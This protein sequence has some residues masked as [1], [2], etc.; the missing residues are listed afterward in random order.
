MKW[1]K[2]ERTRQ[3]E[4]RIIKVDMEHAA[5][6][7]DWTVWNIYIHY[8]CMIT[9][10]ELV[11]CDDCR[12]LFCLLYKLSG[13]LTS[14]SSSLSSSSSS[15]L[16]VNEANKCRK[17]WFFSL[18]VFLAL[19]L[20]YYYQRFHAWMPLYILWWYFN[21]KLLLI[22]FHY[23]RWKRNWNLLLLLFFAYQSSFLLYTVIVILSPVRHRFGCFL[24]VCIASRFGLLENKN[25]ANYW[26]RL[27]FEFVPFQNGKM[28]TRKFSFFEIRNIINQIRK[29]IF[30]A[31]KWAYVICDILDNFFFFFPNFS[32]TKHLTYFVFLTFENLP[33]G[34]TD[35]FFFVGRDKRLVL[36]YTVDA[37][38]GYA[39]RNAIGKFHC[40]IASGDDDAPRSHR[41]QWRLFRFTKFPNSILFKCSSMIHTLYTS[42]IT[43]E[44][45]R[46]A[47]YCYP[48]CYGKSKEMPNMYDT[49]IS[50]TEKIK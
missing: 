17:G 31:L 38:Y 49:E 6:C 13:F 37:H 35:T 2:L 36:I 7:K 3:M 46:H 18:F 45:M 1:W 16:W 32:R 24:C 30:S 21:H 4:K 39:K 22:L 5:C 48:R 42:Y 34:G 26:V 8:T 14:I 19:L 12:L 43:A 44:N 47:R 29:H 10:L 27:K 33:A 20:R 15:L 28:A 25:F 50:P 9:F 40:K 11:Q 41:T 23:F